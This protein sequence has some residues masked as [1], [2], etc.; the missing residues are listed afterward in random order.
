MK[1]FKMTHRTNWF[2][3]RNHSST[4][5]ALFAFACLWI[6]SN[7]ALADSHETA[8]QLLKNADSHIRTMTYDA[9]NDPKQIGKFDEL[10]TQLATL[11]LKDYATLDYYRDYYVAWSKAQ[12]TLC[13]MHSGNHDLAKASLAQGLEILKGITPYDVEIRALHAYM[14]GL[15]LAY[16]PRHKIVLENTKV[17]EMLRALLDTDDRNPQVLYANAVADFNTPPEYGGRKKVEP[18]CQK[19]LSSDWVNSDET[20][21]PT[22]GREHCAVI[23]VQHYLQEDEKPSAQRVLRRA[24]EEYSDNVML[25]DYESIL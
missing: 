23:L 13:A 4:W 6:S 24:L 20:M 10:H 22:W 7:T 15:N 1:R 9:M 17:T 25:T 16:T 3:V 11:D 12:K 2:R 18:L 19:A 8:I 21:R 5:V 14:A